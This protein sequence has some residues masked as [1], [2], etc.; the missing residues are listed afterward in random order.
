MDAHTQTHFLMPQPHVGFIKFVLANLFIRYLYC[1]KYNSEGEIC[2]GLK[3]EMD[4]EH[5]TL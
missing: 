4:V 3:S 5:K 1:L 2:E